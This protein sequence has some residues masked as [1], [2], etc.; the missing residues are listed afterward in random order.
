MTV[1]TAETVHVA[2]G[3]EELALLVGMVPL[4]AVK[5]VEVDPLMPVTNPSTVK[6][7]LYGEVEATPGSDRLI[8]PLEIVNT[9]PL[10]S[11]NSVM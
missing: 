5:L 9:F 1:G 4:L 11:T 7:T 8:C 10:A 6:V 3:V 2:E